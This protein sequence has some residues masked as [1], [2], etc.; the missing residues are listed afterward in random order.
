M[1]TSSARWNPQAPEYLEAKDTLPRYWIRQLTQRTGYRI[2][3]IALDMASIL[4]MSSDCKRVFS[5]AKLMITGQRKN[6]KADIIEATQ[7]LQCD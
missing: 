2:A 4:A 1:R 6:L 5:Q 7:C 3:R